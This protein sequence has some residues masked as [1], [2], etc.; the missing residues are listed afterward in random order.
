M[1]VRVSWVL[2]FASLEILSVVT[3]AQ[4]VISLFGWK[5]SRILPPP[6]PWDCSCKGVYAVVSSEVLTWKTC[7]S[8]PG[9]DTAL[10]CMQGSQYFI[11]YV[12]CVVHC[13]LIPWLP[14]VI[15]GGGRCYSLLYCN[16]SS[17]TRLLLQPIKSLVCLSVHL[18][19]FLR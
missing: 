12:S 15:E 19:D 13:T 3:T 16:S 2:S 4:F 1:L 5:Y 9:Q 7:Y 6:S 8:I 17:S 14:L 18:T 11:H 10:P